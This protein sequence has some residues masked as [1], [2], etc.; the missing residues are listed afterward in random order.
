MWQSLDEEHQNLQEQILHV[1]VGKLTTAVSK[2][3]NLGKNSASTNLVL[4]DNRQRL[5][6]VVK[7]VKYAFIKGDLDKSI[8][9]L[10]T[11]QKMFDPSWFLIMAS[12]SSQIDSVL[13]ENAENAPTA[14]PLPLDFHN[15]RSSVI[16]NGVQKEHIILPQEG[17]DPTS[18]S[19]IPYS[20]SKTARRNGS[21]KLY[22][23]DTVPCVSENI[24][25]FE[26]DVRRLAKKLIRV[27]PDTFGLL[28]CA[29]VVREENTARQQMNFT[30]VFK[31]VPDSPQPRSLRA[32]LLHR[33]GGHS[34]SDRLDLAKQLAK[35]I[36]Y[37][38]ALAFVHKNVCP[39]NILL[40]SDSASSLG[41]SFLVGFEEFRGAQAPSERL[42]HFEWAKN[43]YRHPCRQSLRS[44]D[45]Y[46]MQ[47]DIYSLGVCLLEIGLW[48]P[49]VL[50]A[51][52]NQR[53]PSSLLAPLLEFG[54]LDPYVVKDHLVFLSRSLLPTRMGNKFSNVVETCLTCLD[55]SNLDFGDELEYEGRDG[56]LVG[57]RYI[58][59]VS[60]FSL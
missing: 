37:I 53:N 15:L 24:Q 33:E 3:E 48:E 55:P 28:Q 57:V 2:I 40:S 11:W 19:E 9:D 13:E 12:S 4:R 42:G 6:P 22:I 18:I 58:E 16:G 17:L 1:L 31:T 45:Y 34:L 59:K 41:R 5:I 49:F 43:L 26:A 7:R 25:Q 10:E 21:T 36:S 23:L 32:D 39:E 56:V 38:H 46:V 29:R 14:S 30:F 27:N 8:K 35:S 20:S 52:D 60:S 54:N 44:N 47:H 50:Y 51:V